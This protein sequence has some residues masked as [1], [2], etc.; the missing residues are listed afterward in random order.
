MDELINGC[1]NHLNETI[2]LNEYK[3]S[4]IQFDK[5][6]LSQD[7]NKTD[8]VNNTK[9]NLMFYYT[10]PNEKY[11]NKNQVKSGLFNPSFQDCAQYGIQSTLMYLF[12]PDTNL[13]KW[14]LFFK[15][16]NNLDPVL[17]EEALLLLGKPK[18]TIIKQN[19]LVGLQT[20]QKYC[21]INGLLSTQKSNLSQNV[22][23]SS[24][25]SNI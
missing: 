5:V 14:N 4:Y 3:P 10:K 17:K 11:K 15:N 9:I 22:S 21:V 13:N 25:S 20:P 1:T 24:C 7:A 8:L 23:N 18:P 19:P 12:V 16:K 2:T 6:G